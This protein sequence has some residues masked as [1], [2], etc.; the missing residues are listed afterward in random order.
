MELDILAAVAPKMLQ[1]FL[2]STSQVVL[3]RKD[4]RE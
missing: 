1:R 3:G 2:I 4:T